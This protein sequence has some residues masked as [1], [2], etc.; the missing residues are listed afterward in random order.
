LESGEKSERAPNFATK[1]CFR[2]AASLQLCALRN[3]AV[4]VVLILRFD[5]L[6]KEDFNGTTK[7]KRPKFV[8]QALLS[9][10][11]LAGTGR[12]KL[13]EKCRNPTS[14]AR[15]A[16]PAIAAFSCFLKR[17]LRASSVVDFAITSWKFSTGRH[18]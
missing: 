11:V 1:I 7:W 10:G 16:M 12:R 18:P 14:F 9:L 5:E 13:R 4:D 3:D 6:L 2:A 8:V 15:N 17:G